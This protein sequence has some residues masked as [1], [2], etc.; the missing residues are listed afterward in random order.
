M[1][2]GWK[3]EVAQL[4]PDIIQFRWPFFPQVGILLEVGGNVRGIGLFFL[5][6]SCEKPSL[7]MISDWGRPIF[8]LVVFWIL[9]SFFGVWRLVAFCVWPR[10]G[11]RRAVCVQP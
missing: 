3:V 9:S 2:L 10:V 7:D 11:Q 1:D 8:L 4:L 5:R 6:P